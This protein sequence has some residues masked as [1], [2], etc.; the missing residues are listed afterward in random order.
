MTSSNRRD[1]IKGAALTDRNAPR[2]SN[3]MKERVFCL[4]QV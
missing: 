4:S 3:R 1:V 2:A